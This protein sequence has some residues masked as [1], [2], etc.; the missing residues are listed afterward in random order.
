MAEDANS[1]PLSSIGRPAVESERSSIPK[2]TTA[3]RLDAASAEANSIATASVV[4]EA[5]VLKGSLKAGSVAQIVVAIIATIGLL[6]LLKF[7]MVTVFVSLLLA[8]ILEPLVRQLSRI[9]ISRAVGALVA[10]ILAVG[11]T[12]GLG[13][14]LYGR[15]E[16]FAA[17]LPRYS[18]RIQQGFMRIQEP[19]SKLEKSTS[20]IAKS[21]KDDGQ[22]IPV[23]V[24]EG[25][26][27][28]RIVASNGGA[29]GEVL[30]A[31]GFIP[32]LSYFMLTWKDH[33]H[34]AT[35]QLF[36]EEHRQTAYRTVARI[37]TM[38]RSYIVGNLAVGAAGAT[39]CTTVFWLLGIPYSYF[40]GAISGFISLIPSVGVFLALLPPLAGA[41]GTLNKTGLLIVLVTVTGTHAATMNVLYPKFIGKR[42]RLN[43]LAVLLS[44]LFW[45]WIWGA[46]GLVLAVPIVGAAKIICDHTD[47]LKGLGVWLGN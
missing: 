40:L 20:T 19:L 23:A 12:C 41:I 36:P 32:F 38:I 21:S 3:L 44:L 13:Y 35:V 24:Q 4:E 7:V 2:A 5:E 11:L 29:I 9:A 8:F 34:S 43:P 37:S 47:S 14:F 30:L 10:V 27:F 6:Y 17:E 15:L 1:L 42:L 39:V 31:I 16:D 18:E 25:S 28:S 45:A 33:A 22:A 26:I 46:V